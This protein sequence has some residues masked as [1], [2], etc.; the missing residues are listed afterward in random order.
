MTQFEYLNPSLEHKIKIKAT[1]TAT[2]TS[3]SLNNNCISYF[4][5]LTYHSGIK[6]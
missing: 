2:I 4:K 5:N 3:N 6:L 1:P